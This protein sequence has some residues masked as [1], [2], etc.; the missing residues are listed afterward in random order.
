MEILA[1][2]ARS[3]PLVHLGMQVYV[4]CCASSSSVTGP[5]DVVI[6]TL[7]RPFSARTHLI[8]MGLRESAQRVRDHFDSNA[9]VRIAPACELGIRGRATRD[10][11]SITGNHAALVKYAVIFL[12]YHILVNRHTVKEIL[13]KT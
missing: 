9:C 6:I 10:Y 11:H 4:P 1:I 2:C 13:R 7:P 8:V 12:S 5:C 3:T